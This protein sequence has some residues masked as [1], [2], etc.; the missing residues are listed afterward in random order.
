MAGGPHTLTVALLD[1]RRC[2]GVNELYGVYAAGG[3]IDSV[4]I[5]GPFEAT[6]T[7]DTPSRRA[8]FSCYPPTAARRWRARARS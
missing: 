5:H 8:I 3:G 4:E 6:G 2:E 7:G 1:E